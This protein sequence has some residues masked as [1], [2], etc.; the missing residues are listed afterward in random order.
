MSFFVEFVCGPKING[1]RSITMAAAQWTLFAL[2]S[3]F[4]SK[5]FHAGYY[6]LA[7]A[8]LIGGA[9]VVALVRG[10]VFEVLSDGKTTK[11]S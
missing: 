3:V 1:K 2:V 11:G 4:F 10:L 7:L 5:S 8:F 9:F 6:A